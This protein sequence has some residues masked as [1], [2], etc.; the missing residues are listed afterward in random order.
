[1]SNAAPPV[2]VAPATPAA[3][4]GEAA[5]H[6]DPWLW[7][8]A[9]GALALVLFSAYKFWPTPDVNDK[10]HDLGEIFDAKP[11]KLHGHKSDAKPSDP[12]DFL[13]EFNK[14]ASDTGKESGSGA[15]ANRELEKQL[16]ALVEIN[17]ELRALKKRAT[18]SG[19]DVSEE[20]VEQAR[21]MQVQ[22]DRKA[23]TLETEVG[24]ARQARPSDAVPRWLTGELLILIGGEPEEIAP[25]LEFAAAQGLNRPRLAGSLALAQLEA[26]RFKDAYRTAAAALDQYGQDRYLWSAFKQT[27]LASNQ[28]EPV[29]DRLTRAFPGGL[30]TW[31]K[32]YRRE[33]EVLQAKWEVE[34]KFRRAEALAGD[35]PRVRLI[36]EHRRFAK[37]S[38]GNPLTTI[39]S[40]GRGEI[41]LELFEN[42]APLTVTNFIDLVARKFYDGTSF[43][44]ALPATAVAGGDPNTRNEDRDRD[45]D[46]GPGYVIADE[47]QAKGARNHFRGS[48]SMVKTEPRT[49]GS[50]FF[51][52]LAPAPEMDGNFTVF[53]RI[54]EGQE[55]ADKITRGRTTRKLGHFGRIIP[56][57]L[58]VRAEVVRK[59]P[60]EYRAVKEQR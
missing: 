29:I 20:E 37:D 38:K 27:A 21:A 16:Q 4:P 56:G 39:E 54:L 28:F 45:G 11:G 59:R 52:S 44:L 40:T 46:G 36:I 41:V 55:V 53:G 9:V 30:P 51:L 24:K 34:Q 35:L 25:H 57:D 15:L 22:F 8:V 19:A 31:A 5:W 2:A 14:D 17:D 10:P 12:D 50:R 1:V 23:K 42:E 47:Y 49:A 58:L 43:Y 7:V 6:R 32:A 26:N 13:S 33:A 48:I 3:R 18:A 60:H